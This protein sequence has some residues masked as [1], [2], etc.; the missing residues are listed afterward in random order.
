MKKKRKKVRRR[1][2]S[3]RPRKV[4]RPRKRRR[5][6][7]AG[8]P[9]SKKARKVG[10]KRRRRPRRRNP[11]MGSI[12][13]GVGGLLSAGL[14]ASLIQYMGSN[15]PAIKDNA[16]PINAI[17]GTVGTAIMAMVG[18]GSTNAN[19]R[20]VA[21]NLA[22]GMGLYTGIQVLTWVF[23]VAGIDPAKRRFAG[24]AAATDPF[25]GPDTSHL[26]T[27]QQQQQALQAAQAAAAAAAAAA[28]GGLMPPQNYTPDTPPQ[29][30]TPDTPP[31]N[32]TPATP[33]L[34]GWNPPYPGYPAYNSPRM[35]W[36]S[37]MAGAAQRAGY[38][39]GGAAQKAGY[40]VAGYSNFAPRMSGYS[41]FAP[42]G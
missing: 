15:T 38:S 32:Y 3:S 18:S 6:N 11:E 42:L 7:P 2:S 20:K 35:P 22:A 13:L 28:G 23:D 29:N 27:E 9:R 39:V 25:A 14:I 31:Q 17:V 37:T 19:T 10:R 36:L 8:R 21:A 26:L 41:N 33:G 34:A 40:S 30:Y 16:R 1:K 12:A 24:L 5:K 4:R